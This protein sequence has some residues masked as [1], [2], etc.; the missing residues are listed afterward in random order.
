MIRRLGNPALALSLMLCIAAI[1]L[2]AKSHAANRS[3]EIAFNVQVYE[4]SARRGVLAIDNG[5]QKR[6]EDALL[7]QRRDGVRR[8]MQRLENIAD[9][10]IESF[11]APVELPG[12]DLDHSLRRAEERANL[13]SEEIDSSVALAGIQ[14]MR[15]Q[16]I[17]R[18]APW[19][20]SCHCW[21]IAAAAGLPCIAII[22]V[23]SFRRVRGM[24][25]RR[26]GLCRL[27]GYDVRASMGRCPECGN[28]IPSEYN[29]SVQICS[30]HGVGR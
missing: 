10:K 26:R 14:A 13:T 9:R 11:A 17:M 30:A 25:R 7:N 2:W 3:I 6:M 29:Q 23:R 18:S 27:C 20:V 28:L 1:V 4:I 19:S 21:T 5:P 16:P 22:F 15:W 24:R 8:A 12:E